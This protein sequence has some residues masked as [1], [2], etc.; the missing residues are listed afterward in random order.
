MQRQ[1]PSRK[2]QSIQQSSPCPEIYLKPEVGTSHI[3]K[4]PHFIILLFTLQLLSMKAFT[5]YFSFH[6]ISVLYEGTFEYLS[7]LREVNMLIFT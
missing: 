7:K 1:T 3:W 5:P 4:L 6:K 2:P